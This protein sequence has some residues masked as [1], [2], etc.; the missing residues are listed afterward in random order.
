MGA[1]TTL[2]YIESTQVRG[3]GV[4]DFLGCLRI[5]PIWVPGFGESGG[6]MPPLCASER[7]RQ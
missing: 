4:A 7:T 5:G 2:D 6:T 1:Y 3:P